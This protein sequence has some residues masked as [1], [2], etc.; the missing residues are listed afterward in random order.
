MGFNA[1]VRPEFSSCAERCFCSRERC[2]W[3]FLAVLLLVLMSGTI[4]SDRAWSQAPGTQPPQKLIPGDGEPAGLPV[5]G[6]MV[7]DESGNPVMMPQMTFEEIQRLKNLEAGVDSPAQS[8]VL[9]SLRITGV[10]EAGRAELELTFDITIDPTDG[11]RIA[12]PLQLSNFHRL[13]PPIVEGLEDYRLP[14]APDGSG[15][16][17]LTATD[18]EVDAVVKMRVAARVETASMRS[19]DFD[20]PDVSTTIRLSTNQANA[21]G[22]VVGMRSEVVTTI[23][24]DDGNQVLLV[25]SGGGEF[26]LRWGTLDRGQDNAPLLEA[27]S[28][29]SVRWDGPQDQ[30]TASAQLTVRNLRGALSSFDIRL[31]TNTIA[32]DT[33]TVDSASSPVEVTGPI[34]VADGSLFRIK[35][36]E[37]ERLQR[38]DLRV[39]WQIENAE[40]SAASPLVFRIPEVVGMFRQRGEAT[41]ETSSDYRLRWRSRPWVQNVTID[42]AEDTSARRSYVFRFDRGS[43]E[44]PLWLSAKQRQLRL[45]CETEISLHESVAMLVMTIRPSGQAVD[46]RGLRIDLAS[47]QLRSITDFASGEP[48]DSFRAGQN[49]EIEM[50]PMRGS[51]PATI[52]LVAERELNAAPD[53][54]AFTLPRVVETDESF[55]VQSSR[56]VLRGVGRQSFVIDLKESVGLDPISPPNEASASDH[57]VSWFRILPPDAR[58]RVVGM[59]VEQPQR[60]TVHSESASVELI[61]EELET[62]FS[63]LVTSQ[64]DL[65]GRLPIR[66][67]GREGR[68]TTPSDGKLQRQREKQPSSQAGS[69]SANGAQRPSTSGVPSPPTEPAGLTE[70]AGPTGLAGSDSTAEA[71]VPEPAGS[72][73][74]AAS[75]LT[76][77]AGQADRPTATENQRPG[78]EDWLVSVDGVPAMLRHISGDQYVLISDRLGS[79]EMTVRWRHSQPVPSSRVQDAVQWIAIPRPAVADVTLEGVIQVGLIGDQT[80]DLVAADES[81]AETIELDT[82]PREPIG[83]RLRATSLAGRELSVRRAVLRTAVGRDAHY[84]QVLAT[85]QGGEV[86]RV[87]LPPG[88]EDIA[89]EAFVDQRSRAIR[90][91]GDQLEVLLLGDAA[92]HTVDI[93]VW[94]PKKTSS[95]WARI[96][97]AIRLPVGV[98]RVYWQVVM[99]EDTHVVWGSPTVGRAMRWHFNGWRLERE[100]TETERTLTDWAG[101]TD[102]ARLPPGNSYLYVGADVPTFEAVVASR[103]LLWI[104]VGSTVLAGAVV[105]T[106]LPSTRH[107]LTAIIV[108]IGFTGLLAI[109]PDAA[110]LAGQLAVIA[111]VLVAVMMAIRS[112]LVQGSAGSVLGPPRGAVRDDASSGSAATDPGTNNGRAA[113]SARY[114]SGSSVTA[115]YSMANPREP[116]SPAVPDEQAPSADEHHPVAGSH[117]AK[118]ANPGEP[119]KPRDSGV[120]SPREVS[121]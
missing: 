89:V 48:L 34:A 101:G 38:L 79:G 77:G 29:V 31:P 12:I 55:L 98:G 82:F 63:W 44:L 59:L 14:V 102:F 40:A 116:R 21:T 20:L 4:T 32:L 111:M 120:V 115:T 9:Q 3:T 91:V 83:V 85:V 60:I 114:P 110:V 62:S 28:T 93:R 80:H 45:A 74:V 104:L 58:T 11:Q 103:W 107:P 2:H 41:I 50:S 19:I 6:F 26:T 112:F 108:A 97:P 15:Y 46:G 56:L 54:I 90:R 94:I 27:D 88:T 73:L 99:P 51:D 1:S 33:P 113:D 121:S 119:V 117:A 87:G 17:L 72:E 30:P 67:V 106:Y 13:G 70:P 37:D 100:P 10:A 7:L 36:P 57:G 64:L 25:E 49:R 105:L 22:E 66:L 78:T 118:T 68:N 92:A 39:D 75:E 8:Y 5:E 81:A 76:A 69:A 61:G 109:A 53:E 23:T 35:I 16:V 95:S 65:E 24:D 52:R 84:E 18:R 47:W 43:F 42:P 86:F 96:E 71:V